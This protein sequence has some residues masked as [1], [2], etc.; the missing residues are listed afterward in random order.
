MITRTHACVRV[1]SGDAAGVRLGGTQPGVGGH[2][3]GNNLSD[4][5]LY[6]VRNGSRCTCDQRRAYVCVCAGS[7]GACNL[8]IHSPVHV[9]WNRRFN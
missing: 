8:A 6:C 2:E 4:N 1:C 5:V 9:A 3:I 7:H